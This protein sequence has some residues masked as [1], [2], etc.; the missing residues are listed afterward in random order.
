M[1]WDL[2]EQ[3][4]DEAG[5]YVHLATEDLDRGPV[6]TYCSFPVRGG[7]FDGLWRQVE[8][9][10]V[11]EMKATEG[12]E[13]PLFRHIREEGVRRERPLVL[14]TLKEFAAGQVNVVE[15]AG[16]GLRRAT[17]SDGLCLNEAIEQ[18]IRDAG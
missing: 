11:E 7:E 4:A 10:S 6:L 5:A 9:R 15:Q 8:G 16:G 17:R 14:E 2:I 1:I 3:G 13:L 18:S 12:E